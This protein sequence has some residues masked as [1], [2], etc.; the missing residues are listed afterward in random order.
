MNHSENK[1]T[2]QNKS[3]KYLVILEI[4]RLG[5]ILNSSDSFL[6]SEEIMKKTFSLA[7]KLEFK[8]MVE[9]IPFFR[10]KNTIEYEIRG[11]VVYFPNV[12]TCIS[13]GLLTVSIVKIDL[14]TFNLE[15][16]VKE[17]E[18]HSIVFDYE[19]LE[20]EFVEKFPNLDLIA[21]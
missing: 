21:N 11:N 15:F 6:K 10:F 7:N 12:I 8:N 18:N 4:E 5:F 14:N 3:I 19:Q 20:D 17:R 13:N 16:F 2:M 9:L 1:I